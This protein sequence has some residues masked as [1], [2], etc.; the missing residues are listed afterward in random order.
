MCVQSSALPPVIVTGPPASA[1]YR[2]IATCPPG[3]QLAGG[4]FIATSIAHNGLG[5]PVD[6]ETGGTPTMN[7]PNSWA[8]RWFAGTVIARAMCTE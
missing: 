5:N 2:S 8:D 4:G 1:G 6:T 7:P 3:T